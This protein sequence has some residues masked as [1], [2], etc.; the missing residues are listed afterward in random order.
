METRFPA[1][2]VFEDSTQDTNTY[3]KVWSITLAGEI[4]VVLEASD[5]LFVCDSFHSIGEE[6]NVG[7]MTIAKNKYF[8]YIFGDQ[9]NDY[10]MGP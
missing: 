7:F 4:V 2:F 9:E 6:T 10:H 8:N 1:S 3:F 5:C